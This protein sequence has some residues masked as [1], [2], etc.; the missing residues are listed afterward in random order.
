VALARL[1]DHLGQTGIR[2]EASQDATALAQ[3]VIQRF[4]TDADRLSIPVFQNVEQF[5]RWRGQDLGGFFLPLLPHHKAKPDKFHRLTPEVGSLLAKLE[6]VAFDKYLGFVDTTLPGW[7]LVGEERQFHFGENR[8]DY[9]DFSLSIFQAKAYRGKNSFA[10]L[11]RWVD[12]P[13]CE[14]DAYF[15]EKLAICLHVAGMAARGT[16]TP[17]G[18][19]HRPGQ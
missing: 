6:P 17:G 10:E 3:R 11:L 8:V 14:G 9:P 4:R 18:P 16:S 12:I 1:A 15:V 7:Y 5:D 2:E 19:D 13:W